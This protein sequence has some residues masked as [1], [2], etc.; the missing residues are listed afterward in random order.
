MCFIFW[1][2][3][4]KQ[5]YKLSYCSCC[6]DR[7]WQKEL[8]GR[9]RRFVCLLGWVFCLLVCV[10]VCFC[11]GFVLFWF[12]TKEDI[13]LHV[14]ETLA[15][16]IDSQ[17]GDWYFKCSEV[18][19]A[20]G[21]KCW[22]SAGLFLLV[23]LWSPVTAPSE[24]GSVPFIEFSLGIPKVEFPKVWPKVISNLANFTTH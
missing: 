18:C 22:P 5:I 16:L 14:R 2:L 3:H 20:E 6:Y 21:L 23:F 10:L 1:S 4:F 24:D 12:M 17:L 15:E 8:K 19:K 7:T 13:V 9:R 11:F